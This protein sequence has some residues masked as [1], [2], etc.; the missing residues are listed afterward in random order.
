MHIVR[1][2][3]RCQGFPQKGKAPQFPVAICLYI[4]AVFHNYFIAFLCIIDKLTPLNFSYNV[5]QKTLRGKKNICSIFLKIW[6]SVISI[7]EQ[8]G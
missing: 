4:T 3:S 5:T 7:K 2:Y 8:K 1:I 6:L